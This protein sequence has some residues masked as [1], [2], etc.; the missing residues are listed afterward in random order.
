MRTLF[1]K[2]RQLNIDEQKANTKA[3]IFFLAIFLAFFTIWNGFILHS[4]ASVVSPTPVLTKMNTGIKVTWDAQSG[5]EKYRIY[6]KAQGETWNKGVTVRGTEY[7]DTTC[8]PG[9]EYTYLMRCLSAD[10]KTLISAYEAKKAV[11][12]FYGNPVSPTPV[13]SKE[14]NGVRVSW[15][16]QKGVSTYRVYRKTAT[17]TWN[18][19]VIVS[20]TEYLDTTVRPG[21]EYTYLIRCTTSDGKSLISNYEGKKAATILFANPVSPQVML[22]KAKDGVEISW[23]SQPGVQKYRIYRK[24]ADSDWETVAIAS[25]TTYK[26]TTCES[27]T[28]YTYLIRCV[29]SDGKK[30]ISNYDIKKSATIEVKAEPQPVACNHFNTGRT[31]TVVKQA[32]ETEWGQVNT[33]CAKCGE[34]LD[35]TPVHPYQTFELTKPDG[36]TITVYGYFDEE[37]AH[38]VARLVNEYRIENGLNALHYNDSLQWA[39]NQ[40][41]LDCIALFDHKRPD[42]SRWNSLTQ[43]WV[44][45]GENIASGYRTPSSAMAGWKASPGHNSN[46]LYG[47]NGGWTYKGISVGVFKRITF[48]KGT[49][50]P[51]ICNC[52]FAQN[53]TFYE[54]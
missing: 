21:Y 2:T 5:V 30:L 3:G 52:T 40:R 29:S 26:D 41:A 13:L 53:F 10:G 49:N 35:S 39:S 1:F 46:M 18:K 9:T 25:G 47:Q 20:G 33:Y 7:I 22:E 23:E 27:G 32:T 44:Y 19:G 48:D 28:T 38:E 11:T 24:T 34:L 36:T 31:E 4:Q 51:R 14:S 16:A 37:A 6:R 42:G 43:E 50:I 12:I 17:E 54:Y 8:E 15:T 45:G